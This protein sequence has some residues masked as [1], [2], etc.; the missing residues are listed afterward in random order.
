MPHIRPQ[1]D[2]Y[3][4]SYSGVRLPL[5]MVGEL[6]PTEIHLRNTWFG[7]ITD[8]KGQTVVI[9][10]IVY[11]ELELEHNYQYHSDG[12]LAKVQI[13]DSQLEDEDQT[14]EIRFPG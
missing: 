8:E 6:E 7:A 12:R 5:K 1:Y 4:L 14:R 11:G 2:K 10:K 9:H 13:F 3:Y